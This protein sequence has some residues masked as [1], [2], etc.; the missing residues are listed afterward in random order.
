MYDFLFLIC[1]TEKSKFLSKFLKSV[2]NLKIKNM[3]IKLLIIE[4]SIKKKHESLIGKTLIKHIP[5]EYSLEKKI[6]I[7]FARNKALRLSKKIKARYLCFFDDDC[8]ISRDWME[9]IIEFKKKI[10][11]EIVTGPQIPK[12]KNQYHSILSK[13]PYN[14]QKLRWAATNNVVIDKKI[15]DRHNIE[16]STKLANIGGSD[17]LFFTQ[18]NLKGFEIRWCSN[19]KV[20]ENQ[21]NLERNF[22][23]FVKRSFRYGISSNLIYKEAYGSFKGSLFVFLK[24]FYELLFF[25]NYFALVIINPK[26][27]SLFSI[28]Y[29]FRSIGSFLSLFG[30]KTKSYI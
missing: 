2:N 12:Q 13:S 25:F 10:K 9:K 1:T 27:N 23:W 6:G 7:P 26:K 17:Q 20:F 28:M 14:F 15:L 29:L 21:N 24:F 16:F 5:F 19:A 22:K 11:S 30:I 8:E 4:N 18:L 3:R